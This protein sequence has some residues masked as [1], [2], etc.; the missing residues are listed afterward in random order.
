MSATSN[1]STL[2]AT[3]LRVG[4]A[5]VADISHGDYSIVREGF[6]WEQLGEYLD[7]PQ[8]MLL[9]F[10][11]SRV[12][13]LTAKVVWLGGF[14]RWGL[15]QSYAGIQLMKVHDGDREWLHD[16]IEALAARPPNPNWKR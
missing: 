5:Q 12:A 14:N 3:A 7:T 1:T 6:G 10:D 15:G 4:I 13:T 16:T 8:T 9:N 11:G 2:T